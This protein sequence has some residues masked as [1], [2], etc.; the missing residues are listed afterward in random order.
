MK[1]VQIAWDTWDLKMPLFHDWK[2]LFETIY[3]KMFQNM[4]NKA[5]LKDLIAATGLVFLL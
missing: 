1:S 5:K 4:L 2:E 3:M